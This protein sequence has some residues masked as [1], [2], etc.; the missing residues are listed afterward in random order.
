MTP[1]QITLSPVLAQFANNQQQLM[2]VPLPSG[3]G[4]KT[5]Q[6]TQAAQG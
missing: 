5:G 2:V 6:D 3:K 1:A 4:M